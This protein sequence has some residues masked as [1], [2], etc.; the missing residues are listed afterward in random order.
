MSLNN[1]H[2][3]ATIDSGSSV[4]LIKEK[5]AKK[6]LHHG[7]EI[8]DYKGRV[9]TIN[10]RSVTIKGKLSLN[11]AT[12]TCTVLVCNTNM[13]HGELIFLIIWTMLVLILTT[14]VNW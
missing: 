2:I 12:K 9:N 5:F 3:L 4:S 1:S 14:N 13:F 10:E 7:W 11:L 6:L 8:S